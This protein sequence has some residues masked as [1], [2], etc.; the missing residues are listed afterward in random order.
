LYAIEYFKLLFEIKSQK[1]KI[2]VALGYISKQPG[3][4]T[5]DIEECKIVEESATGQ[6]AVKRSTPGW[7]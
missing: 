3:G 5:E 1:N 7:I 4:P 6:P 2:A